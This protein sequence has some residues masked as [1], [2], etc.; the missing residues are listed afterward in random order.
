MKTVLEIGGGTT[1]YFVRYDIPTEDVGEYLCLDVSEEALT[2]A[3]DAIKDHSRAGR[4]LPQSIR[5][6]A[7]DAVSVSL[8]DGSVDEVVL[9]NVLSAP[10]H[11][12]WNEAGTHVRT[13]NGDG[14]S[15]IL[16]PDGSDRFYGERRAVVDEALR[17]LRS[18][19]KLS[20]Y[21]DLIVYG[22]HAY[23]AI[24][25]DMQSDFGLMYTLDQKEAARIDARNEMKR[26]S[27]DFCYCFDADL[28]PKSSVHRF[29]KI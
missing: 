25:K 10:I 7:M 26:L 18:G 8:P 29:F 28:L 27:G 12:N 15:L 5:Y 21:T 24:L 22:Q 23:D 17:V 11:Y 6:A 2:K 19:G 4:T 13:K 3:E 1:P 14:R 16:S 20:I 9:S